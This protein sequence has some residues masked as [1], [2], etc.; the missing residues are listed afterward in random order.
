MGRS[1]EM[2]QKSVEAEAEKKLGRELTPPE[3]R[4]I[5]DIRSG[6]MLEAI[7]RSFI[8]RSAAEVE[9]EHASMVETDKTNPS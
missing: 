5:C 2:M 9:R 4:A 1:N 8:A 3:R 6:M 7:E